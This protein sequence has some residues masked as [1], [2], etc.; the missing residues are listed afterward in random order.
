MKVLLWGSWQNLSSGFRRSGKKESR[1]CVLTT[2]CALI[3]PN[4]DKR[5]DYMCTQIHTKLWWFFTDELWPNHKQFKLFVVK[6]YTC[7]LPLCLHPKH[8]QWD[9]KGKNIVFYDYLCIQSY[10]EKRPWRSSLHRDIEIKSKKSL[11]P[12]L[13]VLCVRK[14][15]HVHTGPQEPN[16]PFICDGGLTEAFLWTCDTSVKHWQLFNLLKG[17]GGK[18]VRG[19]SS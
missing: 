16:P 15:C 1:A 2:A 5:T 19:D 8:Q 12:E 10:C 9:L 7:R 17:I 6:M 4:K 13:E 3:K 11:S 14:L 18:A